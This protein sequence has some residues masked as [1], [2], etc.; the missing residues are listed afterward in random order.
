MTL[1]KLPEGYEICPHCEGDK[2]VFYEG[3]YKRMCSLCHGS[4]IVDWVTKVIRSGVRKREYPLSYLEQKEKIRQ[5]RIK[6][7]EQIRRRKVE[8]YK[9]KNESED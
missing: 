3:K 9:K 2:F 8:Q 6:M 1:S 5:F 7:K 4:G